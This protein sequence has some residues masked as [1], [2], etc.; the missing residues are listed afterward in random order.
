MASSKT[1]KIPFTVSI[2]SGDG[3]Q[4]ETFMGTGVLLNETTVLT[5]RHVLEQA[6]EFSQKRH[7][8]K[9]APWIS[10]PSLQGKGFVAETFMVDSYDIGVLKLHMPMEVGSFP[11]ILTEVT[12]AAWSSLKSSEHFSNCLVQGYPRS[13][14]GHQQHVNQIKRDELSGTT[15]R[16]DTETIVRHKV[17]DHGIENG[18]SGSPMLI[19]KANEWYLLGMAYLGGESA[20]NSAVYSADIITEFLDRHQVKYKKLPVGDFLAPPGDIAEIH[21]LAQ[22]RIQAA[23][24]EILDESKSVRDDL[25]RELANVRKSGLGL[26]AS[27]ADVQSELQQMNLTDFVDFFQS[28]DNSYS[29]KNGR[30]V[31]D[32]RRLL[33]GLY[34]TGLSEKLPGDIVS[35]C[36]RL[37]HEGSSLPVLIPIPSRDRAIVGVVMAGA[38]GR[39]ADLTSSGPDK[40]LRSRREMSLENLPESGVKRSDGEVVKVAKESLGLR[41]LDTM[42]PDGWLNKIRVYLKSEERKNQRVFVVA[43]GWSPVQK[44]VTDYS[45]WKT[46]LSQLFP[47][48][49]WVDMTSNKDQE[50]ILNSQDIA[51]NPV[52]NNLLQP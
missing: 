20:T 24:V 32:K 19:A 42:D 29:E 37:L 46:E 28:L 33:A 8:S 15:W 52:L 44:K 25:A 26:V 1:N 50:E 21:R 18:M 23:M 49:I 27:S 12:D 14:G 45:W 41:S 48:L 7:G 34:W 38:E 47:E 13:Q 40:S 43:R 31:K 30:G 3:T 5:C 35:E 36:R 9:H 16:A 6:W 39:N 17:K 51:T 4:K 11:T 10:H 2:W 22:G